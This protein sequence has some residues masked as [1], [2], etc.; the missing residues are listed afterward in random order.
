MSRS[1]VSAAT[2]GIL[3]LTLVSGCALFPAPHP[4]ETPFAVFSGTPSPTRPALA[5]LVVTPDSV[6]DIA[7]DAPVPASSRMATFDPAACV[8]N[9]SGV[10][11]G[12]PD[13]GAWVANYPLDA[14]IREPFDIIVLPQTET[15]KVDMIWVWGSQLQTAAGIH[16]GSSASSVAAA[17]PHPDTV[18]HGKVS[19]VDVLN[20][21]VGTLAIEIAH[22]DAKAK[23][24]WG[25]QAGTVLW[26]SVVAPGVTGPSVNRPVARTDA[27][28]EPCITQDD[29]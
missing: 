24:Y 6:G 26:M 10:K 23:R 8:S 4:T 9:D 29:E 2:I 1:G 16:V 19:D 20:G 17:Y 3:V 21:T 7:I 28:P 11:P 22:S 5:A 27:V 25:S 14:N 12:D 15:A 13:A 18:R